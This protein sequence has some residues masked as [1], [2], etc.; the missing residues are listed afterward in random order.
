MKSHRVRIVLSSFAFVAVLV[1]AVVFSK[2][3]V[4]HTGTALNDLEVALI[5]RQLLPRIHSHVRRLSELGDKIGFENFLGT[6]YEDQ[7]IWDEEAEPNYD[8]QVPRRFSSQ[9]DYYLE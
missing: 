3:T 5:S 1:A 6:I 2:V 8:D 9:H 4:D 7:Q